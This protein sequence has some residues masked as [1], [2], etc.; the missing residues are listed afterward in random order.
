MPERLGVVAPVPENTAP[1][2]ETGRPALQFVDVFQS[3]VDVVDPEPPQV[4]FAAW[5]DVPR[6]TAVTKLR[7]RSIFFI[8]EF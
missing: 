4:V 2:P 1:P 7:D 8:S 5:A 3:N 6:M